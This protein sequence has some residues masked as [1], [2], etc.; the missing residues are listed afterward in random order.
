MTA[1][2]SMASAS[3]LA[4][5]PPSAGE[6]VP[7]PAGGRGTPEFTSEEIEIL[8][9]YFTNVDRPVFALTNL[10]EVV[11]GALFAR[12]SRSAK[13]LRRL[14]LD[15]FADEVI[16]SRP[17]R[18]VQ[19]AG[20][21]SRAGD[22]YQRVFVEYGD[23]SVAQLGGAH[24]ACEG[25]S[26]LLTKIL[27]RGRL[28]SYLE[29]STRYIDYS[30]RLP[31]GGYRYYVPPELSGS[32]LGEAYRAAMDNAFESY[33]EMVVKLRSWLED[34]VERTSEDSPGAYRRAL[35]ALVFDTLRGILPVASL[36]NVGLYGTGQ[37]YEQLLVRMRS[38]PLGEARACADAALE[39]LARQVEHALRRAGGAPTSQM[40]GLAVLDALQAVDGAGQ[41]T[42]GQRR[43]GGELAHP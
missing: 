26:N 33:G 32:S 34:R 23:D 13:S 25:A 38:D 19:A 10:P 1:I 9:R 29:Q 12:Y 30:S 36:S 11:K 24:L 39:E 8:E 6:Q 41:S 35:N 43:L 3:R 20:E 16:A 42:G 27:E 40:V 28:M 14:F 5:Q 15:E 31:S 37:A 18:T 2:S 4:G 7:S 17:A 22:L 21:P